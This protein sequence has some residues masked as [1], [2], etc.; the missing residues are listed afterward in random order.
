MLSVVTLRASLEG[1]ELC[2]LVEELTDVPT[3]YYLFRHN[4]RSIESE[5]R[6]RCPIGDEQ[7]LLDKPDG[8]YDF[9]CNPCRLLSNV[10]FSIARIR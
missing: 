1:R 2:T 7:W 10:V 4:A 9:R 5:L 6:R 8:L 3:Y